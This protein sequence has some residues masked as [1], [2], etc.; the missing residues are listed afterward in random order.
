MSISKRRIGP[1]MTK[2]KMVRLDAKETARVR[3]FAAKV[4]SNN[5]A[6]RLLG[7]SDLTYDNARDFGLMRPDTKT[8]V[9]EALEREER[10]LET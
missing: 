10:R 3:N 7:L 5:V 8:K 2:D 4:G 6:R 1:A 9:L